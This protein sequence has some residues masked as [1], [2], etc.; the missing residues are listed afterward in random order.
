MS[1]F[2]FHDVS[3]TSFT[4]IIALKAF[5]STL[6]YGALSSKRLKAEKDDFLKGKVL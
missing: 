5:N 1:V 3:L 4:F 6:V 2:P